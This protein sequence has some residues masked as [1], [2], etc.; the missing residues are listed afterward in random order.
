VPRLKRA[1]CSEPGI[2]RS[3]RGKGFEY[4]DP[5]GSRIDDPEELARIRALAIPP[6]WEEVWI[7]LA[8]NGHLQAT[9]VDAAGRKQY[10]YHPLWRSRRDQMKFDQMLDFARALPG[11][12]RRVARDI[13]NGELGR[14]QVLACALR[15]LDLGFFRIGSEDYAESNGS[16]G[17][18]TM[19]KH[20]VTLNGKAISFDYEAKSG[21]R[22]VQ[23]IVDGDVRRIVEGLKRRRGGGPELL[24]YRDGRR[25]RDLGSAEVNEYIKEVMGADFSAKDFRTWNATILAAVIVALDGPEAKTQTARKRVISQAVKGAAF[26]LG[27]TPAVC[28]ASY[29][30][31][32]VFDRYL[33]GWTIGAAIADIDDPSDITKP[34]TRRVVEDAVLDLVTEKRSPA[35]EKVEPVSA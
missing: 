30:D 2:T 18:A 34:S 23:S 11:M 20:H 27:N 12:R 35:I 3:R 29:I 31:P 9:G 5:D 13:R 8:P 16:Y 1:D 24:A 26:F 33:S 10:V 4:L 21:Q 15:M 17:L 32:R 19:R 25:W 22:R 28:R 7:C 6:A 14:R